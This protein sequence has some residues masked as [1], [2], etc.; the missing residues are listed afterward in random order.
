MVR[1]LREISLILD[2]ATIEQRQRMIE[3]I[4]STDFLRYLSVERQLNLNS[5]DLAKVL[6]R[7]QV[8]FERRIDWGVI[9][10][11]LETGAG[12]KN[13]IRGILENSPAVDYPGARM[14]LI[15]AKRVLQL[16]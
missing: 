12:E 5:R 11:R 1:G 16:S 14:R 7:V 6:I 10:Q 4:P 3:L 9:K 2:P 13:K 15:G 8:E